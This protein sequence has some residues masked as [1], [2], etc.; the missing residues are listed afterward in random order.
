MKIDYFRI[1]FDNMKAQAQALLLRLHIR[2]E[3]LMKAIE[4]VRKDILENDDLI[5]I[6]K[7]SYRQIKYNTE[8]LKSTLCV[9]SLL[10]VQQPYLIHNNT[11]LPIINKKWEH[12]K[13]KLL[14]HFD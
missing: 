6:Q 11:Y 2:D 1:K 9:K 13:R 10:L 4:E 14:L 8:K 12:W 5:E 3:D 7:S